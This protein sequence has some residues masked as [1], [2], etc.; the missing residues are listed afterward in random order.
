MF[1]AVGQAARRNSVQ[2]GGQGEKLEIRNWILEIHSISLSFSGDL[3]PSSLCMQEND[4][5]EPEVR[6]YHIFLML[7]DYVKESIRILAQ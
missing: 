6:E 7:L 3:L 1:Q 4:Q 5:S 2:A